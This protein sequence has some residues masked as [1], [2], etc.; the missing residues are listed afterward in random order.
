MG[1]PSCPWRDCQTVSDLQAFGTEVSLTC[2]WICSTCFMQ[3]ASPGQLVACRRL[4]A[5]VAQLDSLIRD[6]K[7]HEL[8][9]SAVEQMPLVFCKRC[10]HYASSYSRNLRLD[11]L[12]VRN[13]VHTTRS[14]MKFCLKKGM[15]PVSRAPFSKPFRLN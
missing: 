15:R 10:W 8:W 2:F 11:C 5:G 7:G 4:C 3:S 12:D 14:S 13:R 9:G 6:P 1:M